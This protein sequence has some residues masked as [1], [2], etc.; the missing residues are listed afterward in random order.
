MFYSTNNTHLRVSLSEA[1]LH[2]LAKDNGLYM[3]EK[4][5]KLNHEFIRNMD[6]Y[7][8]Q[9]IAFEIANTFFS[10][11]IGE[12]VLKRIIDDSMSFDVPLVKLYDETYILE[13]FHGPTLAFKDFG[14]RFMSRLSRYLNQHAN[15]K[16]TVLVATSGDTG[17]AVAH[18]FF[19]VDG[20]E[21]I[22]LYPNNMVSNI[23]ESQLTTMGG[24]VKAIKVNGTFDDCQRL[25]KEAFLDTELNQKF[26]FTSA[27]SINIARLLPQTF[28]YA[29]AWS[30][31][32]NKNLPIVFSVPSGNFGNLTAGLVLQEMG[33]PIHH[34]IASTNLNDSVPRFLQNGIFKPEP[35][36]QTISNAMDVGN[37]SNFARMQNLFDY[38]LET[39]RKKISAYSFTDEDTITAMQEVWSHHNYILEPHSAIA[40]LGLNQFQKA[41]AK[42]VLGVFL[43]TAHPAKFKDT[44][45][46]VLNMDIEVPDTLK[47]ILTKEKIV[48]E[49]N[50][51][52]IEFKSWLCQTC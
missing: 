25:V 42:K 2:S 46:A 18:G 8:F 13:L 32:K 7:S 31:L 10:R 41:S 6:R 26:Q 50:P 21:V 1:V 17:S 23:Q 43:G 34:F 3:P 29:Y 9:Q 15:K 30:R 16:V 39:F 38:D 11:S 47:P 44:V 35:T 45:D 51:D 49:M 5:N 12:V 24:N 20:T 14:A 52:F 33:V 4:L 19:G 27:N 48:T 22:I 40:Y 28:Y 37:P 36:R